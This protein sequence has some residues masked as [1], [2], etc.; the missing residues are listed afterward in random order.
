[1]K[2]NLIEEGFNFNFNCF[3]KKKGENIKNNRM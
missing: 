1:M 3:I 2:E